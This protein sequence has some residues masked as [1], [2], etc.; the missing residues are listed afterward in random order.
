[1]ELTITNLRKQFKDIAVVD[2]VCL[3]LTPGVW[4]LL[5]ANG[6]G[7]TTLMRMIADILNPTSGKILYD[8]KDVH[9]MGEAYRNVPSS[10]EPN[11]KR[12]VLLNRLAV[13]VKLLLIR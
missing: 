9:T 11:I 4:G 1:M 8:G 7:K 5:G 2:D 6:A 10:H 13:P 12:I 3:S